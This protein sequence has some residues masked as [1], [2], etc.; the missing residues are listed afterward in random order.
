MA[1]GKNEKSRRAFITSAAAGTAAAA[2]ASSVCTPAIAQSTPQLNWRLTSSFPNT[3]DTIFGASNTFAK[4]VAEM[5]DNRFQIRVFPP[6]ELASSLQA[7]DVVSNGTVE[8]AHTAS[9]YYWGKDPSFAFG[10][11]VP[12]GLNTRMQQAWM[13]HGGGIDLM[14]D[15]YKKFNLYALP[16][17]NTGAQMGGWYRKEINTPDDMKG[18]KIRIGGFGG[19]VISRLGAVPQQI[20]GGE[21]YV[22]LEKGVI[23]AAEWVGP[24]DDE[25]LELFRV[26]KYYYYPGWWEGGAMLQFFFNLN[27]WNELP[28][29]YQAVLNSA[30]ALANATMAA[31]YDIENCAALRR[32]VD[33][34]AE[35]RVFPRSLLEKFYTAATDVYSEISAKNAEFKKLYEAMSAVRRDG[36][37][38]TQIA[39]GTFDTFMMM[40]SRAGKL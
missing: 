3:L 18:L 22:S 31:R 4:A 14:N 27:K 28:K 7:A 32:L 30:A 35:L 6:N 17:G 16:G 5:T 25:K 37:L 33:A 21:I 19:A 38:W 39:D 8:M 34:G 29:S 26:A 23:D 13:Y 12:F 10:T 40:Q 24:Y 15:F 2:A 36:Y 11:T 20:A 9:Y 1:I